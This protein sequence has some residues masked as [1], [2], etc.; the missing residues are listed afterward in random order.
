MITE[1]D[2][3]AVAC[4]AVARLARFLVVGAVVAVLLVTDARL[5]PVLLVVAMYLLCHTRTGRA[6]LGVIGSRR[7]RTSHGNSG[8]RWERHDRPYG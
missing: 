6:S 4:F 8:M 2:R 7:E 3:A 1:A 5:A